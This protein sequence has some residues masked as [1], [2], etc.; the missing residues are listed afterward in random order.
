MQCINIPFYIPTYKIINELQEKNIIFRCE[1]FNI[2]ILYYADD[3]L[4]LSH[5]VEEAAQTIKHIQQVAQ[6]FGLDIKKVKNNILIYNKNEQPGSIEDI[7]VTQSI[8]YLG[9][10]ITNTRNCYKAFRKDRINQ[11][12]AL[13][14]VS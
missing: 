7:Q 3:S 10:K 8:T 12:I 5:S 1:N 4:L 13:A 9:V 6:Q 11:A 14:N 2:P